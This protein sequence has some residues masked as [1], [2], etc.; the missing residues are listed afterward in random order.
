MIKKQAVEALDNSMCDIMDRPDLPFGGKTIVFGEDFRQV[1]PVVRKG[2]RAHIVDASL[3]R[4]YLWDYMRHL[5]L[6]RN[7]RA[8]SDP[9]FAEYLLRIGNGIEEAN[10]DGEVRLP[11][12]ICMP[13]TGDGNDLDR[14]IQCIFPNTTTATS[15]TAGSKNASPTVLGTVGFKSLVIAGPSPPVLEPLVMGTSTPPVRIWNRW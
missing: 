10:A 3:R 15:I 2:S 4:S 12:E 11:D 14:L 13:Y 9:W 1:L 6:V 5:K 8:H 7:M